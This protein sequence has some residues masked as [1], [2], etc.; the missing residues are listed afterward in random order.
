ML[1]LE[2]VRGNQQVFWLHFIPRPNRVTSEVVTKLPLPDT[3]FHHKQALISKL[4]TRKCP[5]EMIKVALLCLIK[6]NLDKSEP[7]DTETS[8]STQHAVRRLVATR[9]R[10]L[11]SFGGL[12]WSSPADNEDEN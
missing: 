5:P 7:A 1:L 2:A 10:L 6:K 11:A 9:G 12:M 8:F 4:K 3:I